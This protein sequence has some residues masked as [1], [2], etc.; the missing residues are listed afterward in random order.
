M[1][2]GNLQTKQPIDMSIAKTYPF[3]FTLILSTALIACGGGDEQGGSSEAAASSEQ[4]ASS[5]SSQDAAK[6]SSS[7]DIEVVNGM[8]LY[9]N[10]DFSLVVPETWNIDLS[11][12]MNT[13][14]ILFAPYDSTG[15]IFRENVNM[16]VD[17]VGD[18]LDLD[19]YVAY[20]K[21]ILSSQL[22]GFGN[23]RERKEEDRTWL[24][25]DGSQENMV[26][27]YSQMMAQDGENIYILTFTSNASESKNEAEAQDIMRTF[28]FK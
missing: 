12:R 16:I 24:F 25:Y 1:F 13:R 2:S 26:L 6:Q 8:Q 21:G 7:D 10:D 9:E 4:G 11:G 5:A 27:H 22:P 18:S 23:Y 28:R 3:L 19:S 15:N 14:M 20:A 17:P